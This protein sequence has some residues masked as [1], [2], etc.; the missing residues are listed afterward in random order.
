VIVFLVILHVVSF[1]KLWKCETNK[2]DDINILIIATSDKISISIE[3]LKSTPSPNPN[4]VK[5]LALLISIVV[6]LVFV[7]ISQFQYFQSFQKEDQETEISNKNGTIT[8]L[9]VDAWK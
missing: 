1:S 7:S 9:D 2:A 8:C 6:C 5:K 3:I 4:V